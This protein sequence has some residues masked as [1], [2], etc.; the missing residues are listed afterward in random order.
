[1]VI[2]NMPNA[3]SSTTRDHKVVVKGSGKMGRK[4][5]AKEKAKAKGEAKGKARAEAVE[6]N[7]LRVLL[8]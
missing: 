3:A 4:E 2:A 5:K 8:Q 1:M 7:H 6:T